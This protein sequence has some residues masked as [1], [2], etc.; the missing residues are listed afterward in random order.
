MNEPTKSDL[1]RRKILEAGR[2]LV[3]RQGFG[4]VGIARILSASGVPKGSFYYYFPSKE[5]FGQAL[6][7]DY[8]TDYLARFDALTTTSLTAGEKLNRFWAA[9][10]TQADSEG[11][12]SK[13]L[14]VKLAA[15]IADL[16]DEMREVLDQGV[17]QLVAR[18][19]ELL[20]EGGAD[21]SVR[22][23]VD[24]DATAQMLYAK[25]LGAAILAKLSRDDLP[26]RRALT[27]TITHLSPDP[28]D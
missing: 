24:P 8:V 19:A 1:T 22:K 25:W 16:S 2:D 3:R 28:K 27:E 18:I 17:C 12:A 21:A 11:I 13:C 7:L 23:F 20:R 6:L 26:L 4:G 15:E 10:L 9:W 5:A 14:V